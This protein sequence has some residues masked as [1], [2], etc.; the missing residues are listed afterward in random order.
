MLWKLRE[1]DEQVAAEITGALAI[2]PIIA[3]IISSRGAAGV[4]L[5]RKYLHGTLADLYLPFLFKGMKSAVER[6]GRS[7]AA[8][9]KII[10]YG[11]SDVDGISSTCLVSKILGALRVEWEHYLPNRITEGYGISREGIKQCADKHAKLIITVDCGINSH[12]EIELAQQLGIDVIVTDHHEP[13]PKLP[14]CVA[15]INPKCE[16]TDY[17]FKDLAGVGVAFKLV[18]GIVQYAEEKQWISPGSIDLKEMLDLVALGTVA[19]VV[20]LIDENRIM[21]KAGL[22]QLAA[23]SKS[24]LKELKKLANIDDESLGSYDI[25]FRLAPR[26]NAAGRLGNADMALELMNSEDPSE[27]FRLASTIERENRKRQ[28]IEQEI[29]DEAL[30]MLQADP[31]IQ[32]RSAVILSSE[33]W[34]QGVVGIVALRIAKFCCR[35][36]II[37]A[38]KGD[39]GKGSVRSIGGFHILNA[40][41][42]CGDLLKSYGGHQLAAGFSI[43]KNNIDEFC[44]RFDETA[45]SRLSEDDKIPR[46]KIDCEIDLSE[47]THELIRMMYVLEPFGQ[48]NSQPVFV[49]RN[50]FMHCAPKIVGNNHL[51]MWFK[52]KDGVMEAIAFGIADMADQLSHTGTP[53]DIAYVPKINNYYNNNSLQLIIK[54]IHPSG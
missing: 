10:I 54:D 15:I 33:N 25:A 31:Q 3:G 14:S 2:S 28:K 49:S 8:R 36:T 24:G 16:G 51:K 30:A 22:T 37:I 9:E 45:C 38:I 12:E 43:D 34:H 21:V 52:D 13:P 4:E 47:V 23:T 35:P 18:E 42:E 11:D 20:P 50:I 48:G 17:P 7:V 29:Y 53:Y 5:A 1:S 27:A 6:I 39:E 32:T 46:I 19:D 26:L 44:Q 41:A 40:I